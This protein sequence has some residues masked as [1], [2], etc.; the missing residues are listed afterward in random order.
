MGMSVT[1]AYRA[2]DAFLQLA[3]RMKAFFNLIRQ[4]QRR[5]SCPKLF[6]V[7]PIKSPIVAWMTQ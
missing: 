7:S 4:S 6:L 3:P 5:V 1:L 2:G